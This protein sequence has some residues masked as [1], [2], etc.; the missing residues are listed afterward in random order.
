MLTDYKQILFVPDTAALAS[1]RKEDA[2]QILVFN[3]GTF[4]WST[5]GPANGSTIFAASGSGYWTRKVNGSPA[6]GG[7]ASIQFK[8]EGTNIGTAGA[9]TEINY[10]GAGISASV[11]GTVLTVNVTGGGGGGGG[12]NESKGIV[13]DGQGSVIIAS[14][15]SYGY[16]IIPY[17]ATLTG[18][19]VQ[20][21]VSG[22]ILFDIK[23]G[24][25]SIIGAGNKPTLVSQQTNA[26]AASGWTD[27][28]IAEDD[29]IEYIAVSATTV[30]RVT[31]TLFLTRV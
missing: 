22:S 28:A 14:N 7:Q 4:E 10:T 20:A 18:W 11:T 6:T 25:T 3:V 12:A 29:K 16:S 17:A 1:K 13:L 9:I 19:D 15:T 26:E 21:D 24:G 8:D 27:T 23:I 5:T 2:L 30:T 31:L